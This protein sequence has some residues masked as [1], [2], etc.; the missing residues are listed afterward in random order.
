MVIRGGTG[1][2]S[3]GKPADRPK[4]TTALMARSLIA[5]KKNQQPMVGKPFH[6]MSFDGRN[7][8]KQSI[9]LKNVCGPTRKEGILKKT[10]DVL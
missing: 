3:S 1:T 9:L 6:L 4:C 2:D 7:A 5:L 8:R 10:Q